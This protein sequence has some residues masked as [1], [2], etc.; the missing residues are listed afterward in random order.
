MAI[1]RISMPGSAKVGDV[2]EIKTLVQHAMETGNRRDETGRPVARDIINLLVVTYG[3]G[4]VF[5][6]DLFPGVAANPYI[7]FPLAVTGA[8]D[9]VFAWT[10]DQGTTTTET[11]ALSVT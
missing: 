7:A 9:V 6:M 2:I 1:A 4:E 10:D 8:G 11:R 3:G 5:R